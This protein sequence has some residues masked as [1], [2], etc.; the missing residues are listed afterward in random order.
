SRARTIPTSPAGQRRP[1][2]STTPTS[3]A[4]LREQRFELL[5]VEDVQLQLLCLLELRSRPG[6]RHHVVGPGPDPARR[7]AAKR[8]HQRLSVRPA[9][10]LEG[11]GED[12]GLAVEWTVADRI[13]DLRPDTHIDQLHHELR[14]LALEVAKDLAGHVGA[15]ALDLTQVLRACGTQPVE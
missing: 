15:D 2:G 8:A 10:R 6:P 1:G 14:A 4:S 12:E 3:A 7:L 11:A 13:D 5:L 9:H